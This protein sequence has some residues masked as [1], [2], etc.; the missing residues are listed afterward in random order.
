MNRPS[1]M[2][3]GLRIW[4]LHLRP[5]AQ[6]NRPPGPGSPLRPVWPAATHLY[7][8]RRGPR[9]TFAQNG[10]LVQLRHHVQS[11]RVVNN[12]VTFVELLDDIERIY[13][14]IDPIYSRCRVTWNGE[15]TRFVSVGVTRHAPVSAPHVNRQDPIVDIDHDGNGRQILV[16]IVQKAVR[17][18]KGVSRS[19]VR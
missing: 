15:C 13:T 14:C 11:R 17:H 8:L 12:I 1:R 6:T 7:R 9:P 5:S 4:R 16:P 3:S 19:P 18:R 2:P 10:A